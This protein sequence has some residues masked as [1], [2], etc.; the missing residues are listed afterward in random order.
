[1]IRFS[2]GLVVVALGVL[3]GGVVTSKL[4][5]VYVSI[6]VSALALVAWAIGVFLKR[7]ELRQELSGG[8]PELVPA[9]AGV[10]AVLS[11]PG[12]PAS[13]AQSPASPPVT[14]V[15]SAGQDR[16][17]YGQ[18][19]GGFNAAAFS[20]GTQVRPTWTPK[21]PTANEP[22]PKATPDR[23]AAPVGGW[24]RASTPPS[25]TPPV[26]PRAWDGAKEPSVSAGAGAPSADAG[27]GTLR[28][29]FDR[30]VPA[31]PPAPSAGQPPASAGKASAAPVGK[32]PAAPAGE[33]PEPKPADTVVTP[34]VAA[35]TPGKAA[36]D[37]TVAPAGKDAPGKITNTADTSGD[38]DAPADEDDDWPTRY[39]WLDDEEADEAVEPDDVALESDDA[40]A[41]EAEAS[42][43][44]EPTSPDGSKSP[45]AKA[46]AETAEAEDADGAD[47]ALADVEEAAT[48]PAA[49]SALEALEGTDAA[50]EPPVLSSVP[51]PDL[52]PGETEPAAEAQAEPSAEAGPTPADD[53]PSDGDESSGAKQETGTKMVTV[54]P[55]VPRYHEPDCILIRF[56]PEG[57]VQTKSIPEAKAAKCTPCAACQPED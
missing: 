37:E 8:R 56:M 42:D 35:T 17:A 39:S 27:S 20:A 32:A 34:T 19:D 50:D 53:E 4:S 23:A 30:P 38:V 31:K 43:L 21:E 16:S 7:G 52:D 51:N 41:A 28:S 49:H 24:G 15:P 9:G 29:W 47:V 26:A 11:A 2:A 46:D 33:A 13:G 25:G 1:M 22:A 6:A 40:V 10:G 18:A 5:L 3:I 14:P 57:D 12:R 55:G 45:Q 44:P 54:V 48:P 36:T